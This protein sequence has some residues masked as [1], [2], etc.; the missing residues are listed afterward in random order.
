MQTQI[1][2]NAERAL[3]RLIKACEERDNLQA[4]ERRAALAFD[5]RPTLQNAHRWRA[6]YAALAD[7]MARE[8]CL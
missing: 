4:A 2:Q 3:H 1:A 5:A 7:F 8:V 6:A